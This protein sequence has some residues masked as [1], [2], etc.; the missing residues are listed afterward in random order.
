MS[1]PYPLPQRDSKSGEI[2][3]KT[4]GGVRITPLL[5]CPYTPLLLI[6]SAQ[7]AAL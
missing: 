1:L 2:H 6:E 4:D 7:S 3:I 5:H